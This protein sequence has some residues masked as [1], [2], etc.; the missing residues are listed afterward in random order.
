MFHRFMPRTAACLFTLMTAASGPFTAPCFAAL[1]SAAQATLIRAPLAFEPRGNSDFIARGNGFGLLVRPNGASLALRHAPAKNTRLQIRWIGANPKARLRSEA[2]MAAKSHYFIGKDANQWRKGVPNFARLRCDEIYPGIGL[3]FYGKQRQF[4]YD[5]IVA[6]HADPSRI[7]LRFSGA[8]GVKVNGRGDLEFAV[9]GGVLFQHKPVAFQTFNGARRAVAASYAMQ[10]DGEVR[11]RLAKYDRSRTL[12]IDPVLSYSTYLGGSLTEDP[13]DCGVDNAGNLYVVGATDSADFPILNALYPNFAGGPQPYPSDQDAFVTKYDSNGVLLFST[14]IGG[15]TQ[16]DKAYRVKVDASGNPTVAGI[17]A[18]TDFPTKNAYQARKKGGVD[19]FLFKL[20]ADGTTLSYSTYYGGSADEGTDLVDT[21]DPNA[22]SNFLLGVRLDID[23]SGN[24]YLGGN[25]N[26]SDLPLK[27]PF[28]STRKGGDDAFIA[29]FSVVSGQPSLAYATYFGGSSFDACTGITVDA[30]GKMFISGYTQS[31]DFPTKNAA[32]SVYAGATDCWIAKLDSNGVSLVFSTYLGGAGTDRLFR[33]ALD[34]SGNA[35]VVGRTDSA[36]FPTKNA[37]VPQLV[38]GVD[39]FIAKIP[40]IGSGLVFSTYFGG[41]GADRARSL[42]LD[43]QDNICIVGDVQ[44]ANYPLRLPVQSQRRGGRDLGLLKLTPN[45]SALLFSSYLGGGGEERG[46]SIAL[47][48]LDRWFVVSQTSSTDFPTRQAAQ[49]VYGG[50][51]LDASITKI[52]FDAFGGT[53]GAPSPG[54]IAFVSTRNGSP[55]IYVMNDDGTN[56]TRLTNNTATD[57]MPNFQRDGSRIVFSSNR[58]GNRE[59]YSMNADGSAQ[60]RLT[61]NAASDYDPFYSPDGARIA[62]VSTRDGNPEIY[63]MNANGSGVVRLT[64]NAANDDAPA[65]SADGTALLFHSNRAGNNDIY[66]MDAMPGGVGG[67]ARLTILARNDNHPAWSPDSNAVVFHSD[68]SGNYQIYVMASDGLRQTPLTT[69]RST[70]TEPCFSPDGAG[71]AFTS[72]RGTGDQ[73]IYTMQ[74]SGEINGVRQLTDNGNA[75]FAPTWAPGRVAA[76]SMASALKAEE[77]LKNAPIVGTL[78]QPST[79]TADVDRSEVRLVFDGLVENSALA[80]FTVIINGEIVPIMNTSL[81]ADGTTVSLQLLP[82]A[83]QRGDKVEVIWP[84][85]KN[86]L[87]A[88]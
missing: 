38:G 8:R 74:R 65:W 22:A 84:G 76:S 10:R 13:A 39:M 3:A 79:L 58:N 24:V 17:T 68:R 66:V 47:D 5:W 19:A 20:S 87:T 23:G 62:F 9:P 42:V 71:I 14:Y 21:S 33:L 18:S 44:S 60:T 55:E 40:L 85:G 63:S 88:R 28:Q 46:V 35:V 67:V 81:G 56:Q 43:S 64:N 77:S 75:D 78:A 31:A 1:P 52:S 11:L 4:E 34:R 48:N 69:S 7:R 30:V 57:D 26:S 2:P 80:A 32:Q 83:L 49:P 41:G 27:S 59:I 82:D 70:N 15:A 6:P 12:V 36:D 45:G 53:P 54:Q 16:Q 72:T 73:E 25:T 37:L 29:K 61:T 86:T 50:G 51:S